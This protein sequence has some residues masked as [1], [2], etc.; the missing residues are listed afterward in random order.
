MASNS[1]PTSATSPRQRGVGS[2]SNFMPH[3]RYSNLETNR[4]AIK[5][6]LT[7][8]MFFNDNSVFHRLG[9][10]ELSADLVDACTASIGADPE[11]QNARKELGILSA[12]AS[13]KSV[14]A[15]DEERLK[16][17]EEGDDE[18]TEKGNSSDPAR[19]TKREQEMYGPLSVLF[20]KIVQ[21]SWTGAEPQY[22][23][24]WVA[25][26]DAKLI[27]E[28]D[29]F[30]FPKLSPDFVLLEPNVQD[31][32]N[33]PKASHLWRQQSAFAEVKPHFDQ[34][35]YAKSS[36]HSPTP[37]SIVV[38]AADYA[39]LH[40]SGRPFQ[41]FSVVLLIFGSHF[42]VAIFD[43]QAVTFSPSYDIWDSPDVFVRVVRGLA[44]NASLVQ[45][46]QDPTAR[47]LDDHEVQE[48]LKKYPDSFATRPTPLGYPTYEVSM[49]AGTGRWY[50]TG[51]PIWFSLSLLGRGT[52]VWLVVDKTSGGV[53]VLKTA[54]RAGNRLAESKIYGML[55]GKT[56]R[57][58][59]TFVSGDDVVFPENG[60][61]IS[62]AEFRG[63]DEICSPTLHRL[64][65]NTLGK[66]IWEYNGSELT[67]LK[68]IRAALR[69]HQFLYE[70]GILHRDVS[71]GNILLAFEDN[72]EDGAEGFITDVEFA[73]IADDD[74]A[75]PGQEPVPRGAVMT[76]TMQFMAVELLQAMKKRQQ[77]A[78][79]LYH[80]L[81]S[82]AWVLGYSHGR[83][84][85]SSEIKTGNKGELKGLRNRFL[86][87]YGCNEPSSVINSR[88]AITGHGPLSTRDYP[89]FFSPVMA[90]VFAR[91]SSVILSTILAVFQDEFPAPAQPL[92]YELFFNLLDTAITNLASGI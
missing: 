41:L 68:G 82:F 10:D 38:Q 13:K 66:P 7:G 86:L 81:E 32:L 80:D 1:A 89:S 74:S 8:R 57:G 56:H 25:T 15:L 92:S 20:E 9:I 24:R 2:L 22:N 87:C 21:F 78:H 60:R 42:C 48:V 76:G 63:S 46:G 61:A 50:T 14:Q 75:S 47:V 4:A 44:Q 88:T 72:P 28:G 51:Y 3:S 71:A 5:E 37:R 69:G 77:L 34:G 18:G 54:W 67:L 49:G 84:H 91:L 16:Q 29:S 70:N 55:E 30:G 79:I 12:Q 53:T 33:R 39:R 17:D 45:L 59:A 23:R 11:F 62:V 40:L 90:K 65:L 19:P 85:Y 58:L 35:P 26:S 64:F 52:V 73:Y 27:K 6:E 83:Y 43:R 31:T 36:P